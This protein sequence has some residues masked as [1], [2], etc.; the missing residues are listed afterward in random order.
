MSLYSSKLSDRNLASKDNKP[1]VEIVFGGSFDPIHMGHI[2]IIENL[3]NQCPQWTIRILPCAV[4]ALKKQ[5]TASFQQRVDMIRLATN[6][7]EHL[8]IDSREALRDGKSYTI[9]TLKELVNE[10][11]ERLFLLV[12]GSDNLQTINQ[13]HSSGELA[14]YCHL[15]VVNRKKQKMENLKPVMSELGFE[16]VSELEELVSKAAGLYFAFLINEKDISSTSIRNSLKSTFEQPVETP[17]IVQNYIK[18][19]LIYQ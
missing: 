15:V 4:P 6:E 11:P 9:D 14:N 1:S 16:E 2:N 10:H 17:Q 3:N 13:W 18:E 5:T 12:V 8:Q 7:F 19:N